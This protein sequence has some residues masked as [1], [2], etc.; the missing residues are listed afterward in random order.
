LFLD[1]DGRLR[2]MHIGELSRATLAER[3]QRIRS[4]DAPAPR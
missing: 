4:P 1:A 2:D 3:L